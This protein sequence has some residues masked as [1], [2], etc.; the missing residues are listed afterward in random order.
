MKTKLAKIS[1][2]GESVELE[3]VFD[4]DES[5]DYE[6]LASYAMLAAFVVGEL[7]VDITDIDD[8]DKIH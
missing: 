3:L 8:E 5:D 6:L 7:N 1:I 4:D 2:K